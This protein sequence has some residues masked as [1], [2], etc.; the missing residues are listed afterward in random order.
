MKWFVP[1]IKRKRITYSFTMPCPGCGEK[2]TWI[3]EQGNGKIVVNSEILGYVKIPGLATLWFPH[4][5]P[6]CPWSRARDESTD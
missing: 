5:N 3:D 6:I 2:T 1:K 4:R